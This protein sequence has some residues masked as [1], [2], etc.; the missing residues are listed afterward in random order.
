MD[1]RAFIAALLAT[2][3]WARS[4]DLLA[5]TMRG[6]YLV[7]LELSGANDGLNTLVPFESDDYMRYRP[8]LAM[9]R[10]TVIP[11]GHS[12]AVGPLGLNAQLAPWVDRAWDT[13][14]AVVTGL[15]YPQQN[16]SHFSSIRL[17]E[18][19]GDGR[20]ERHKGWLTDTLDRLYLQQHGQI[21]GLTLS[22]AM[23]LFDGGSGV[24][25]SLGTLNDL[26]GMNTQMAPPQGNP[27]LA[28][29]AKRKAD[30]VM[31]SSQLSAALDGFGPQQLPVQ[32]RQNP[33]GRQLK[34][35]MRVIGSETAVPVMHVQQGGYDTHKSQA[36]R[37]RRLLEDLG[38]NLAT[39]RDGLI[40]MG[41]WD[42][43]LVMTY[44]EF[45]RRA[46]ENGNQGTD[47]GTANTHFLMGGRLAPGLYGDHPSLTQLVDNDMQFS[48]D[49]RS[50][51]DRV[52]QRWF[53]D[54]ADP[55]KAYRDGR[56][57]NLLTV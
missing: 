56:L 20:R 8:N 55:W 49:Y 50:L 26:D 40:K 37:H 28:L 22:G 36:Y 39:F 41:R 57:D 24:Y 43:V 30:L 52:C 1:R 19:G 31:G 4:T 25:L 5:Q 44:S 3:S 54:P 34:N 17:W 10:N 18:T 13:D 35:V 53:A 23:G 11:I 15:G 51:Y 46:L 32:M 16:R 45:G 33:L 14:L 48:M 21:H 2:G 9:G 12:A 42:D 47:H 6:K 7:L 38:A 29:M 27:F